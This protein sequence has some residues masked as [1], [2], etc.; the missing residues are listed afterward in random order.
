MS[1]VTDTADA[2]LESLIGEEVNVMVHMPANT[3]VRIKGLL[4]AVTAQTIRLRSLAGSMKGRE[5]LLLLSYVSAVQAI[6]QA[7]DKAP[8]LIELKMAA[9][10][11]IE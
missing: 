4:V 8:P 1:Q 11:V 2:G 7:A 5:T 3:R 10:T 6:H 9:R